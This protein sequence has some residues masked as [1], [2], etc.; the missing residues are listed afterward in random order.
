MYIP[1]MLL[2]I[3]LLLT[4]Q[5]LFQIG[6]AGGLYRAGLGRNKVEAAEPL[7]WVVYRHYLLG[8]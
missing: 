5:V 8:S 3:L 1:S 7:F 4:D 2:T 6:L